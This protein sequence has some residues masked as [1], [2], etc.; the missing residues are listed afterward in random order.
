[1]STMKPLFIGIKG[2]VMRI[3][4]STGKVLWE[5]RLAGSQFV[6]IQT[7]GDDLLAA[8]RGELYC[9]DPETGR[10]KWQNGLP[11]MGWGIATISGDNDNASAIA[12]ELQQRQQQ[13]ANSGTP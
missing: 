6:N 4:R 3:D 10:L 13:A 7:N 9:L 11:G 5:A 1:M 2:R 8:T 12:Q